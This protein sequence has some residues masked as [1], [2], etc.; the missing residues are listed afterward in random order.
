MLMLRNCGCKLSVSVGDVDWGLVRLEVDAL[1]FG[2]EGGRDVEKGH[3]VVMDL[4]YQGSGR[5]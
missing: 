2:E 4:G 3:G 1:L 5:R